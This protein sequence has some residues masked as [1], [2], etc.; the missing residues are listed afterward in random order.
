M[1]ERVTFKSKA[2]DDA[3]GALALPTGTGKAPALVLI[4]EYWGLNAHIESLAERFAAEG[5]IV[6]APDLYRGQVTRS[7]DEA[8]RLMKSLDYPRAFGDVAGAVEYL[9]AHP[10]SNGKVAMTGFCMGGAITLAAAA[11]SP[12]LG[13]A[14]A[15]PFYGVPW[16]TDYT[17]ID[18]PVQAHFA[19][20]DEWA[21]PAIALDI[22]KTVQS[23]GGAM[24]LNVY[25]AEHAFMN[26]TRPEV[27]SPENA[28]LAWQR[29]V[30]FLRQHTDGR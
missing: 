9:R 3:S 4:Q 16:K 23:R 7:A 21:K 26:D 13:L 5:F 10:R 11:S 22:Q 18:C 15:V 30:A 19:A 29:A 24:E 12:S 14:A 27:Y 28:K 20:T 8:S 25:D 17:L 1:T 2:G 6:L